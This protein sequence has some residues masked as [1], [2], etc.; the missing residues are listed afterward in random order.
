MILGFS[1]PASVR[2]YRQWW[3]NPGTPDQHSQAQTWLEAGWE[4]NTVDLHSEWVRF[5]RSN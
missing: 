5:R 3:E 2:R 4:V 1:L